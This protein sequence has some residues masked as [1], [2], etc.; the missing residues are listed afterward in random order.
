[1]IKQ[2]LTAMAVVILCG[3]SATTCSAQRFR[4]GWGPP[5]QMGNGFYPGGGWQ[6][7]SGW[8]NFGWQNY[9]QQNMQLQQQLNEIGRNFQ[10]QTQMDNL[11]RQ[12]DAVRAQGAVQNFMLD[13]QRNRLREQQRRLEEARQKQLQQQQQ[14]GVR[15]YPRLEQPRT[16]DQVLVDGRKQ[17]GRELSNG[18]EFVGRELSNGRRGVGREFSNAREGLGRE[19]MNGRKALFGR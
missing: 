11:R 3:V 18:R 8:N 13:A 15:R 16:A 14:A 2:T 5:P 9:P 6:N 7:Q 19:W 1:M 17:I 10:F 12:T 4:G